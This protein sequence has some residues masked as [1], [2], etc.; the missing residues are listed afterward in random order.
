MKS[1][2]YLLKR[3][4]ETGKP[5]YHQWLRSGLI[6]RG[7]GFSESS[8][9]DFAFRTEDPIE[10]LV[11]YEYLRTEVHSP[12]EWEL[13]AYMMENVQR[14]WADQSPSPDYSS[15]L[16]ATESIDAWKRRMAYDPALME[17]YVAKLDE[18]R[19]NYN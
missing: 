13:V 19:K 15:V 8:N 16:P 14:S 6:G 18:L 10:I 11:H 5:V 7:R 4:S 2:Y 9:A 12:Y 17:V 3:T 1:L